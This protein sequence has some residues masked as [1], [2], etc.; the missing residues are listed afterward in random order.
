M[1]IFLKKL[2][3]TNFKGVRQF[4][5]EFENET[6]IMGENGTGKTSLKDAFLWLFFG[7]DST[8]RKDFEIKTL[9]DENNPFHNL[10]HEVEAIVMVDN[11]EIIIRRSFREKWQKKRGE[12]KSTF[13]GHET[14]FFWNDVPMKEGEF[15]AKVASVFNENI[16]K[17]ITNAD[18]FNSL[19]WQDR[20]AVLMQMAGNISNDQVF[21]SMEPGNYSE[22]MKALN[23]N[24]TIEEFK[25]EIAAKK[26]KIKDELD[27]IPTRIEEANRALPAEKDYSAIDKLIEEATADLDTTESLLSNKSKA[28]K[29]FQDKQLE[30]QKEIGKL[31]ERQLTLEMEIRSKVLQS[32]RTRESVIS[33]KSNELRTKQDVKDRLLTKYSSETKRKDSL[34]E[35]KTKLTKKWEEI[36]AEQL[37][38]NDNDFCCP[39]CQRPFEDGDVASK[40]EQL[41]QNFNTDKARRLKDVTDRGT[42]LKTEI[43]VLDAEL[44]NIMAKG[45][46]LKA[47]I[48]V[49]QTDIATLQE[50]NV[51]LS[52]DEENQVTIAIAEDTEHV[53][54]SEMIRLHEEE[55]N[56]K[57]PEED[58]TALITRKKELQ[59]NIDTWKKE[60]SGKDQR[61]K[62]LARITELHE[63]ESKMAAELA[64]LEGV[65]FTIEGFIKS[66]MDLLESRINSRFKMVKF[67]MF[68]EQING[69]RVEA[70]TTLINGVPYSDANTAS[71]IQ[72][73]IDIINTLSEHYNMYGPIWI[74][75]RESVIS[76]PETNSQIIN[77]IV[78]EAHHKLTVVNKKEMAVA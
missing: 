22:L 41:T 55:M 36:N 65:E 21:E 25:K 14:A 6:H 9:D 28:Q 1:N 57:L 72:A 73:G 40:K 31:K 54:N 11:E 3:L 30:I 8:D 42:A 15:N 60:L 77:L 29:E 45:Q 63:Q 47:E 66:K 43:E 26:K 17:L 71:K 4:S 38:F 51:R 58:N 44:G 69:G 37:T 76:I 16:F 52:A 23:Q 62:V 67:K 68:E 39:S 12:Q 61:E 10:D 50:E 35:E 48:D 70:C 53:A 5:V 74:D 19:K 24:K 46:A 33:D 27:F 59:F 20:R 49:L 64:S 13:T 7:K 18:Y 75:N 32:K 2:S 56:T 34:V 78:S